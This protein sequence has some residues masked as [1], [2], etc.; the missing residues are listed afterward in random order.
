[1]RAE[2]VEAFLTTG[3]QDGNRDHMVMPGI[4]YISHSTEYS[5]LY[6]AEELRKLHQ[7]C[8]PH[9]IPLYLDGARLA[10]ALA[11]PENEL[12]LPLLTECCDAF[13]IVSTKCGP[14]LGE[15]VVLPNKTPF[16]ISSPSSNSMLHCWPKDGFSD[17]SLNPCLP[18]I[19]IKRLDR[20]PLN[21]PI[22]SKDPF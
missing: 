2:D 18:I 3:E 16:P 6:T 1:M 9:H 19:S 4:V 21:L 22:P 14:L 17:C 8:A 12:T 10:Y 13:Y 7:V 20:L 15:A 5:T 11:S